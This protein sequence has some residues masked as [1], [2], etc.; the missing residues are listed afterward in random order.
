MEI[1]IAIAG[2][3]RN[4]VRIGVG[5]VVVILAII[6]L[7]DWMVRSRKVNAFHPIARFLR[8]TVG[9]ILIPVERRVVGAGGLPSAAPLWALAFSIIAGIVIITI[10]DFV[11]GQLLGAWMAMRGG[12][13]GIYEIL[14]RWTFT[15][16]QVALVIRVLTSWLPISPYSKW[17]RWVFPLT[18]PIL[19]PL[20]QFVPRLGMF[21]IT[22]I[23]AFF[24]L[25]FLEWVMLSFRF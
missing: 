1:V 5:V 8:Q 14:V 6:A 9:P 20:R 18:E 21:D 23:V 7:L 16:L 13:R 25:R 12:P 2:I 10:I 19:S 24:L 22:P 4:L 3:L 11:I 15:I 17:I